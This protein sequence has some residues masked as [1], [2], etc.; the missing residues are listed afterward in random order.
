M[1]TNLPIAAKSTELTLGKAKSFLGITAKILKGKAV[2]TTK[3]SQE[4][5]THKDITIIGDLM[6]EKETRDMSW[7]DTMEYAKNLRLGGYDDWRLPTIK[8]LSE[9]VTLCGG[10]SIG[11]G[12]DGREDVWV[13]NKAN[14]NYQANYKARG[15]VSSFYW[16]STTYVSDA[17]NAWRVDFRNGLQYLSSKSYVY[18]VRCVRAGR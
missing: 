10:I 11:L 13:E 17:S 18:Y 8:E 7:N 3:N 14:E 15:F 12:D 4:L 9:V 1:S 6:W 16:S 2:T 5:T